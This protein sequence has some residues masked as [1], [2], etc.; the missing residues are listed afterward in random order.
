MVF[1]IIINNFS[2][3]SKKIISEIEENL[4]ELISNN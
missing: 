3:P 4:R 1:S 2:G